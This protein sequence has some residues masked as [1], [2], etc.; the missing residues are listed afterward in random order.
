[1]SKK[2]KKRQHYVQAAYLKNFAIDPTQERE[3][4]KI[5]VAETKRSKIDIIGKPKKIDKLSMEFHFLNY[6]VD[7]LLSEIENRHFPAIQQIVDRGT[8]NTG[9]GD[10]YIYIGYQRIRGRY[11]RD[12]MGIFNPKNQLDVKKL[13]EQQFFPSIPNPYPTGSP[14]DFYLEKLGPEISRVEEVICDMIN[15]ENM[16]LFMNKTSQSFITSDNPVVLSFN[17]E[18]CVKI[19]GEVIACEFLFPLSP[20]IAAVLISKTRTSP[21]LFPV[22]FEISNAEEI[23]FLNK[24]I[25]EY[26]N[27]EIYA[28][29][30]DDFVKLR[31]YILK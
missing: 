20:K 8:L 3:K 4:R 31:N 16:I 13:Q 30:K 28:K 24:K 14:A 26:S 7:C 1:M 22:E 25:A 12:V 21:R 18:G 9:L 27:K 17:G 29:E 2:E 15:E 5:W 23:M 11:W 6:K 10:L 19:N